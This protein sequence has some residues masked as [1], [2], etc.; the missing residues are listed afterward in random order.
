VVIFDVLQ[1]ITINKQRLKHLMFFI[2][3][4]LNTFE[5]SG[6]IKLPVY[7]KAALSA[8]GVERSA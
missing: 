8:G 7:T 5:N 4:V 3:M 6:Q 1:P 2:T